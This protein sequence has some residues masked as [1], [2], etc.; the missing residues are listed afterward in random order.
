MADLASYVFDV[1]G[2][3]AAPWSDAWP[4]SYDGKP[5]PV[6]AAGIATGPASDASIS[7]TRPDLAA[8]DIVGVFLGPDWLDALEEER[9]VRVVLAAN[10]GSWYEA[11]FGRNGTFEVFRVTDD[12]ETWVPIF[13]TTALELPPGT[14]VGLQATP[15]SVDLLVRQDGD[16]EQ[17]AVF[18]ATPEPVAE[19]M[20]GFTPGFSLIQSASVTGFFAG[21]G[22][23]GEEP[24]YIGLLE[25]AE[26]MALALEPIRESLPELQISPFLNFNPTPPSIDIYPADL[27]QDGLGFGD[28]SVCYFTVRARVSTADHLAG[29][30]ALLRLLDRR[31]PESVEEA[32]TLDQTLGG[33]VASTA[34]APEGVSGFRE[35]LEDPQSTG[36]LLGCEWRV[37][38]LT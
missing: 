11:T 7:I 31:A 16:L 29:Q 15:T 27:F 23:I 33:V 24:L 35:Y 1:D 20:G 22:V 18:I 30:R 28:D 38:V 14:A 21:T 17:L 2:P 4:L 6:V 9:R 13:S 12:G 3:L 19:I 8:V 26:A 36:R 34:V 25:I 32:L 37:V 10:S 5:T